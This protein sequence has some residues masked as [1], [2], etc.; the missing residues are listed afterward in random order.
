MSSEISTGHSW[1]SRIAESASLPRQEVDD[2]LVLAPVGIGGYSW[3]C[4]EWRSD[5]APSGEGTKL[6]WAAPPLWQAGF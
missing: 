5:E 3:D 1:L 2:S 4:P 6:S